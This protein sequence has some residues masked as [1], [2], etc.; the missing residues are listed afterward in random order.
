MR[1]DP[2][3]VY[4]KIWSH[5]GSLVALSIFLVW[6]VMRLR[7]GREMTATGNTCKKGAGGRERGVEGLICAKAVGKDKQ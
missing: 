7:P 4:T 5:K 6:W 1:R 2:G 3:T